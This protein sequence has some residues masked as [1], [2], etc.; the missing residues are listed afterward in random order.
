M[1][2]IKQLAQKFIDRS[3]SRNPKGKKRDDAAIDFFCRRN[4]CSI[5]R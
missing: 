2:V 4:Q 3:E 1:E 5:H